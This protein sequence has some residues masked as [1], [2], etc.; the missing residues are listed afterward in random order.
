MNDQY[1]CEQCSATWATT[2]DGARQAAEHERQ[3]HHHVQVAHRQI[4]QEN[5]KT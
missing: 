4:Q 2:I 3:Q 5:S 1:Q